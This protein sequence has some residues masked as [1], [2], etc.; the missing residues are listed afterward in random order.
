[1]AVALLQGP[2]L[3][4]QG[5]GAQS[6]IVI[7]ANTTPA[8]PVVRVGAAVAFDAGSGPVTDANIASARSFDCTGCSTEAVAVQV[9]VIE[10]YPSI[11]APQNAAVAVNQNCQT[12]QTFAYASQYV[13]TTH[14]VTY[15]SES[16]REQL[17]GLVQ[18]IDQVTAS[19]VSFATMSAEL[20]LISAQY[21][22]VVAQ[23]V[24]TQTVAPDAFAHR[25]VQIAG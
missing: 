21:Y 22:D 4:D 6:N 24:Q 9:V 18:E 15:L 19:G 13:I 5:E 11:I 12:C 20:D 8:Q 17:A 1:M 7:A 16:V 10:G 25:D 14:H 3:A 2:A 23:A